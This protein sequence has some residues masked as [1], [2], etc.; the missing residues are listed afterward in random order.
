MKILNLKPLN[1]SKFMR[2][3]YQ[4]LMLKTSLIYLLIGILIGLLM[5]LSYQFRM[6]YRAYSLKAVHTHLILI[7]FV[8]QMI[9]GVASIEKRFTTEKEGLIY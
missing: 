7:G 1:F 4:R 8:I 9:M 2:F 3:N 6:F 5:F